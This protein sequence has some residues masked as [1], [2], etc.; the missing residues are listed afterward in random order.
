MATIFNG[1]FTA[2]VDGPFVVFLI[3]M[4]INRWWMP[5]KWL[6]VVLTMAPM[7]KTLNQHPEKGFLRG[8]FMLYP[9]G[10]AIVQYWRTLADLE[11]FARLPSEPHVPAWRSF[12]RAV[13]SDG[14]VGIWHET[15]QVQAGCY[16]SVYRNMPSFGLGA[17]FE[18][19]EAARLASR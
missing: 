18:H 19:V 15:Y 5:H 10:L 2:K 9:R 7:L 12:N 11:S 16:D 3:G 1:R 14:S 4:R 8:E 6:P 13:G 17:A